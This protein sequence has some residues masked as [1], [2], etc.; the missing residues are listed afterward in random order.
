MTDSK[1]KSLFEVASGKV[2]SFTV[3]VCVNAVLFTWLEIDGGILLWSS[4]SGIF[5]TVGAVRAFFWRRLF[6]HL[7]DGFLK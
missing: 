7:G 2:V 3:G 4:L 5:V 1:K 6:N